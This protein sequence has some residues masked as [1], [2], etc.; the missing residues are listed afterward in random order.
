MASIKIISKKKPTTC[1]TWFGQSGNGRSNP[2]Q[3]GTKKLPPT[4]C[5]ELQLGPQYEFRDKL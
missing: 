4:I 5:R 2:R 1:D 3:Y